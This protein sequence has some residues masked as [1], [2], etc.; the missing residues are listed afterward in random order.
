MLKLVGALSLA[1]AAAAWAM[2]LAGE[3]PVREGVFLSLM[4]SGL[5][6]ALVPWWSKEVQAP[7]IVAAPPTEVAE[8]IQALSPA[9]EP[10]A[11]TAPAAP[12]GSV[13]EIMPEVLAPATG[14]KTEIRRAY[15]AYAAACNR[16]GARA[17]PPVEFV[18]LMQT[19]CELLEIK[20]RRRG[21]YV[22]LLDVKV[23]G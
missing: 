5:A 2:A 21:E 16:A 9:I 20:T 17:V 1:F 18:P 6:I 14:M 7:D 3:C 10:R 4:F 8:S 22:Y 15:E 19:L 13:P 23:A 12:F 11:V